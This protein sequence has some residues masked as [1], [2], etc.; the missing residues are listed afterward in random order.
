MDGAIL[1]L[2]QA[3]KTWHVWEHKQVGEKNFRALEKLKNSMDE[4]SVLRQWN[5]TYYVQALLYMRF[6][7]MSRH[8]LTCST[9]G[10]RETISIR[11][12]ADNNEAEKYIGRAQRIIS[13]DRPPERIGGPDWWECKFCPHH[14]TCHQEQAPAV[15]CRTCTHASARMDGTW[16]CER[17]HKTL[18]EQEQR[19]GCA[20]HRFNPYLLHWAKWV[21]A[22]EA[23]NTLTYEYAGG[24]FTN[25]AA[26]E[27]VSSHEIAAAKDKKALVCVTA[28]GQWM[29]LRREF[30]AEIVG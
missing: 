11:T 19:M 26:P 16:Y 12:N 21:D 20:D 8:Y 18:T 4:K 10:G 30:Q 5:Q 2:L 3:P 28:N 13:A 29:Q 25:G 9:P 7:G 6:S 15:N 22:S 1:G 14:A 23:D 27:G 24:K 17:H